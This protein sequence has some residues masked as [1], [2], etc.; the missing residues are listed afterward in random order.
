MVG[1]QIAA[2]SSAG[3]EKGKVVNYYDKRRN[4]KQVGTVKALCWVHRYSRPLAAWHPRCAKPQADTD[5][6]R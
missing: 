2:P 6:S 1:L 3:V 4:V 5:I